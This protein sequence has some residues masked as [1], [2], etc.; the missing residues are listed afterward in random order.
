MES[1]IAAAILDPGDSESQF[2]FA[3]PPTVI[4]AVEGLVYAPIRRGE[5]EFAVEA[6]E[7]L[8]GW[9]G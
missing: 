8:A 6:L 7:R 5:A 4:A 1:R 2:N 3:D 9:H